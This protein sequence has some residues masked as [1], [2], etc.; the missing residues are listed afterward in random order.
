MQSSSE[1]LN[2]IINNALSAMFAIDRQHY[3]I[4]TN[5]ENLQ[6]LGLVKMKLIGHAEPDVF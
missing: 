3:F 2:Q 4:L 5:P 6:F 1:V